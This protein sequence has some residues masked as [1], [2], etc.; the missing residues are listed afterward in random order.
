MN[1][2]WCHMTTHSSASP[3]RAPKLDSQNYVI[4]PAFLRPELCSILNTYVDLRR[5]SGTLLPPDDRVTDSPRLNADFL[6]EALLLEQL[7]AV[8]AAVGQPV[9]PSYSYL[10]LHGRGAVLPRH[11]DRG[12]SELGVSICISADA[13]WP[14]WFETDKGPM[15]VSLDPGDA[16][17]YRGCV[18]P[19]WRE[20][21]E[22]TTQIQCM[23]FYVA[24][25][26]ANAALRFD[27]RNAV[28]VPRGR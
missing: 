11:V 14:L 17:L 12:A 7:A 2:P 26:G 6:T 9:W 20:A 4:L 18:L 27:G 19:H 1:R 28:G 21:F 8:E 22:G 23:L 13:P 15:A 16:V 25:N 3:F 24:R 5:R 10:R